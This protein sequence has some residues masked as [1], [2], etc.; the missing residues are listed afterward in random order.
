[1]PTNVNLFEPDAPHTVKRPTEIQALKNL[2]MRIMLLRQWQKID[3]TDIRI[4][5]TELKYLKTV[6]GV[7]TERETIDHISMKLHLDC[8]RVE[9]TLDMISAKMLWEAMA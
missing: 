9:R 3:S 1:M 8:K 2:T 5:R 6:R 7:P 4:I